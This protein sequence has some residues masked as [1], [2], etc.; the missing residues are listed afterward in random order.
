[1]LEK[2]HVKTS[3]KTDTGV[4]GTT[5]RK[6]IFGCEDVNSIGTDQYNIQMNGFCNGGDEPYK[7]ITIKNILSN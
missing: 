3:L 5:T 4:E 7:T 1:M 6:L 2:P